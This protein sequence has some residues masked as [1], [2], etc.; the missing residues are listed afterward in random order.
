MSVTHS[1][2]LSFTL[3]LTLPA[4]LVAGMSVAT[5]A[6][7]P[8]LAQVVTQ[9]PTAAK[10]PATARFKA[11]AASPQKAGSKSAGA[12]TSA[13]KKAVKATA[14]TAAAVTTATTATATAGTKARGRAPTSP[15]GQPSRSRNPS[16]LSA[17]YNT[18]RRNS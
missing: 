13:R 15:T 14:A 12:K 4:C 3:S 11:Q 6:H 16:C 18:G 8:A 9:G 17:G 2:A 7:A 10:S 1:L 5:L